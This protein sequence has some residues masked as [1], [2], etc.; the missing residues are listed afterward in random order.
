[1]TAIAANCYFRTRIDPSLWRKFCNLRISKFGPT[2]RGCRAGQSK[3]QS[4]QSLIL[5]TPVISCDVFHNTL[6]FER[7]STSPFQDGSHL[8]NFTWPI[9]N[10]QTNTS[11]AVVHRQ[12][13]CVSPIHKR[14]Q[15]PVIISRN[16]ATRNGYQSRR[17][18]S[19]R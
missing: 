13:Q 4:S 11:D 10:V 8:H 6:G 18:P 9:L 7:I 19:P 15:I 16:S 3:H 17:K 1:M 5:P 2:R 14:T 12:H